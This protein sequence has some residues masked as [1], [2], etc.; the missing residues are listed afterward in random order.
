MTCLESSRKDKKV[1]VK[2]NMQL[3]SKLGILFG[4]D[5]LELNRVSNHVV[6]KREFSPIHHPKDS[7][8]D[9]TMALV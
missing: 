9:S 2:L 8:W 6:F 1:L 5:D 7:V 4:P 3:Y